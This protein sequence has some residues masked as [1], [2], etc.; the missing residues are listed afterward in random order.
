MKFRCWIDLVKRS[1]DASDNDEKSSLAGKELLSV[2][3]Y[4][5][6]KAPESFLN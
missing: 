4:V 2:V 6:A 3:R 5:K 1:S